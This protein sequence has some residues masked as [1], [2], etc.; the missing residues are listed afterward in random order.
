MSFG[1]PVLDG[2]DNI[3][4]K[5][6]PDAT[7]FKSGISEHMMFENLPDSTG[8]YNKMREIMGKI[9]SKLSKS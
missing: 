6:L 1:T 4:D 2:S 3:K 8:K 9:R 7:K 5:G